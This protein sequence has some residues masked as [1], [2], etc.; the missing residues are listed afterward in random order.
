MTA[1]LRVRLIDKYTYDDPNNGRKVKR[2]LKTMDRECV[3]EKIDE[4]IEKCVLCPADY[5]DNNNNVIFQ[6]V[7]ICTRELTDLYDELT[8][9]GKDK[10]FLIK[11]YNKAHKA[12]LRINDR[13][14]KEQQE[15]YES[16]KYII[17]ENNDGKY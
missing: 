3:N 7:R 9:Y 1:A 12:R 6:G 15:Q 13:L 2:Y 11:I 16:Q 5:L 10:K 17:K 14:F 4:I 8:I